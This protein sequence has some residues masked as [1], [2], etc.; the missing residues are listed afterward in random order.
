MER[1]LNDWQRIKKVHSK[2]SVSI[3]SLTKWVTFKGFLFKPRL[4][5][6]QPEKW[7]AA[8]AQVSSWKKERTTRHVILS[9]YFKVT[10][11]SPW[12]RSKLFCY[13]SIDATQNLV[14]CRPGQLGPSSIN[15]GIVPSIQLYFA[16]KLILRTPNL[17][18]PK[19]SLSYYI[20]PWAL[21][22]MFGSITE[23]FAGVF[24]VFL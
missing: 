5:E 21:K 8:I 24:R 19:N 23:S 13:N 16:R 14:K 9:F 4:E 12:K 22:T 15:G 11:A 3:D 20:I 17:P 2:I 6:S 10:G 1:P 7:E 18:S